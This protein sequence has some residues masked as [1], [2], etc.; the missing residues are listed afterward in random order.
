MPACELRPVEELVPAG[1]LAVEPMREVAE[2]PAVNLLAPVADA[3]E[4]T[5]FEDA[6]A[7]ARDAVTPELLIALRGALPR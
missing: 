1:L 2:E 3:A 6:L 7:L 5:L 4:F